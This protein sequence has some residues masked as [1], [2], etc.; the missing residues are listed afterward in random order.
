MQALRLYEGFVICL[1]ITTKLKFEERVFVEMQCL[2]LT[3]AN[4]I[5]RPMTLHLFA[6]LYQR[7]DETTSSFFLKNNYLIWES[8]KI[9]LPNIFF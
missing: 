4:H 6:M 5:T 2:R 8:I 1:R 7:S 9:G 3:N